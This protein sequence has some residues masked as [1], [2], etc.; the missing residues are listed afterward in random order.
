MMRGGNTWGDLTF[1]WHTQLCT[2]WII[3]YIQTAMHFIC[4][5]W[6][7]TYLYNRY[8]VIKMFALKP[9]CLLCLI[10]MSSVC[11]TVDDISPILQFFY[12]VTPFPAIFSI[13][14]LYF[15]SNLTLV[16]RESLDPSPEQ[17]GCFVV[18]YFFM[19]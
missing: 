12:S 17:E 7:N 6:S 10:Y 11:V 3:Y 18:T 1:V 14:T 13:L 9:Q 15:H 19:L 2:L 4:Q 8:V 5:T 16:C